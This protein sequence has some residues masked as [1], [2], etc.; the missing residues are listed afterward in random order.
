MTNFIFKS[1]S[2]LTK[3]SPITS[4]LILMNK[5]S[6]IQ[7]ELRHQRQDNVDIKLMLNRLL[8]EKQLQLQVDDF[9]E[10]SPKGDS[11]GVSQ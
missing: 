10:S 11:D 4:E 1:A 7:S 9:Y 5:L 2:R 8:I 6:Q 3:N